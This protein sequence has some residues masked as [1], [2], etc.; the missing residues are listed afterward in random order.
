MGKPLHSGLVEKCDF[1]FASSWGFLHVPGL[2]PWGPW[3]TRLSRCFFEVERYLYTAF[4]ESG[5]RL[6]SKKGGKEVRRRE[7]EEARRRG[8]KQERRRGGEEARRR[9]G[10]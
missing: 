6:K 1:C 10:E 5:S 4:Q 2:A 9:G 8:G 3:D 7:G